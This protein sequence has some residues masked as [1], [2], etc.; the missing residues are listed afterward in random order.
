[1]PKKKGRPTRQELKELIGQYLIDRHVFRSA[2]NMLWIYENGYYRPAEQI[3][4]G[5]MEKFITWTPSFVKREVIQ[6][7]TDQFCIIDGHYQKELPHPP[8]NYF[9]FANGVLDLDTG[10]LHPHSPDFVFTYKNPHQIDFDM[11]TPVT[12]KFYDA[13]FGEGKEDVIEMQ[14]DCLTTHISNKTIHLI[15]GP[16]DSGKTT[17]ANHTKQMLGK[18]FVTNIEIQ[19]FCG[20]HSEYY[21]AELLGKLANIHSDIPVKMIQYTGKLKA[22]SGDDYLTARRPAGEPITFLP[23]VTQIYTANVLPPVRAADSA[24]WE[25]IKIHRAPNR[26]HPDD[27]DRELKYKLEKE[28]PGWIPRVLEAR[29]ALIERGY[30][31][32]PHWMVTQKMWEGA[33][34]NEHD[35]AEQEILIGTPPLEVYKKYPEVP[36]RTLYYWAKKY[37][38]EIRAN[39]EDRQKT[40]MEHERMMKSSEEKG[41]D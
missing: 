7:L 18:E 5:I 8:P 23:V 12:E 33:L 30:I 36:K 28:I 19:E 29:K 22:L 37:E 10:E 40:L 25:R 14:A 27:I 41:G 15:T 24:W 26:V 6:S 39:I 16:T 21:T 2:G 34:I 11:E 20:N 13:T 38:A 1:V 35:K 4:R 3:V 31:P 9:N 32:K 17:V